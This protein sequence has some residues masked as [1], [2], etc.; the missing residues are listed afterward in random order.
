MKLSRTVTYAL[1]ATLQLA[2][3]RPGTPVPCSRL[4]QQGEMPE[5]FLL[6]ILRNLV[7]HRIL[8]STRGVEGGY[9]LERPAQQI[10]L[11]ELIEAVDGPL[12]L[13]IQ[14]SQTIPAESRD[15]LTRALTTV[16]AIARHELDCVKLSDL[17][18]SATLR[19]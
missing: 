8:S 11:L 10:S 18:P 19:S 3:C 5:R 4:A 2:Q 9:T 16:T 7:S 13:A 6:Q 15:K 17:L 1:Q 12:S 14:L